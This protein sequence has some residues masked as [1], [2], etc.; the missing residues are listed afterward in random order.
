MPEAGKFHGSAGK[1]AQR[2]QPSNIGLRMQYQET[3]QWCWIA[4]A[5]S[6]NHFYDPSSPLTQCSIMTTVGHNINQFDP[7]TSACPSFW[8]VKSNPML[9]AVLADPYTQGAEY[10]LGNPAVGI[11]GEYIKPG[12]VGDALNVGGNWDGVNRPSIS[13]EM[14]TAELA[15]GRPI[16]VDIAWNAGG[17]HCIAIAGV[18]NNL[19][20]ILD[21]VTGESVHPYETFPANYNG[22]AMIRSYCLTKRS[23]GLEGGKW[24]AEQP[25]VGTGSSVGPALAVFNGKLVAAWK[26][27]EGDTRMFWSTFDGTGWSPEQPGV[28]TGTSNG[29]SL[30]AYNGRLFAAWK[31]VEGDTR[32]FWSSFDGTNWSAEQPGVGTGSS[33]GPALAVINGKLVAAWKGVEGDTRMFWSTFD[34]TGW[35]PEQQL[36]TPSPSFGPFTDTCPVLE[37][38]NGKLFAAWKG[39]GSDTDMYWCSFDGTGWTMEQIG[40]G[41]G[42]SNGPSLA[43]FNG[44]LYAAWKGVPTDT[45]MFFSCFDGTN[46]LAEQQGVGVG[47]SNGPA[48]AAFN[49]RLYAAWKG[50][51]GDS[52]MFWSSFG[53]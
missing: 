31:G 42:T 34:G 7:A 11:P 49:G 48:I 3:N 24:S 22:G 44:L 52:R 1:T 8:Y 6:V 15:A 4:V 16:A 9:A 5:T 46:W 30:A 50:V 29:P 28:G 23:P 39:V 35:S 32:M 36:T 43:E 47:T 19:L 51:P 10:A 38:Y 13:L 27:V 18:L 40:V 53:A 33:V 14:I 12:G 41:L 2:D 25:G 17:Q 20:L 37:T 45:R 21:P 26:G